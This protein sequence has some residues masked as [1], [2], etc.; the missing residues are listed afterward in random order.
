M[1]TAWTLME[2]LRAS[3]EEDTIARFM[4]PRKVNTVTVQYREKD[5]ED[6]I[7]EK[8]QTGTNLCG[9]Y[10]CEYLHK[11][12]PRDYSHNFRAVQEQLKGFINEQ[13]IDPA[14]E[15]YCDEK[16]IH[17]VDPLTSEKP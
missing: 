5:T 12:A 11:A 9:Y 1:L 7:F 15:F 4:D 2:I 6:Y 17:S 16:A 3:K 10:I 8:Q 13:I 14:G